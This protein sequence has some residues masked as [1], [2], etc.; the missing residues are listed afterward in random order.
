MK[1]TQ[2]EKV[3]SE[4]TGFINAQRRGFMQRSALV[5]GV[6]AS[7]GI[8]ANA[9]ASTRLETPKV[10]TSEHAGYQL[11]DKVKEYYRKARF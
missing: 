1:K 11:T 10:E 7:G 5:G 8:V 9:Q 4:K 2:S 6:A 3:G